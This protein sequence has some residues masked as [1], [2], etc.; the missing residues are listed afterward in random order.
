MPMLLAGRDPDHVPWPNVLDRP[1]P[2]L[3]EAG[4]GRHDEGLAQGM[5]VPV[6]PGARLER[7]T[8]AGDSRR[9]RRPKEWIE[10]YRAG[11]PL[12]GSFFLGL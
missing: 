8:R 10:A 4:P 2:A 6:G 3:D 9:I 12:R 1:R 5:G 7:D 11:E